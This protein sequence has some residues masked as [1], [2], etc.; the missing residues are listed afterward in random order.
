VF[1][2]NRA[3]ICTR[4][5][6]VFLSLLSLEYLG[7][8]IAVE[9]GEQPNAKWCRLNLDEA[10]VIPQPMSCPRTKFKHSRLLLPGGSFDDS[11]VEP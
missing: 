9:D 11:N 1:E 3:G 6:S 5:Y 8:E 10:E 4:S 7:E 2:K